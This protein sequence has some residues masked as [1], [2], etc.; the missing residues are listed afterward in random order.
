MNSHGPHKLIETFVSVS[1]DSA[2]KLP[3][4]RRR[5][6]FSYSSL[7]A[8]AILSTPDRRLTLREI[9]QW[10]MERYPA[11]YKAGD[12]GW[13]NTIRHN[14]SLN[15]CFKKIPRAENDVPHI[16][17][18]KGGYWTVDPEFMSSFEN[19][20]F[21]KGTMVRRK[22]V[23]SNNFDGFSA[24]PQMH[25]V[26]HYTSPNPVEHSPLNETYQCNHES[27]YRKGSLDQY[28]LHSKEPVED[29]RYRRRSEVSPYYY[30]NSTPQPYS[31]PY[32]QSEYLQP[33]LL[34]AGSEASS[35][36]SSSEDTS[37]L[38]IHNILN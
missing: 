15:K 13:Q 10:I 25:G 31:R 1:P 2:K 27:T 28:L 33:M 19:G 7:I 3:R 29:E 36:K 11:M 32:S 16:S 9:Y 21:P 30:A 24:A 26:F 4:K 23:E 8:Q 5:P 34:R 38:R 35:C 17:K 37:V 12:T 20:E 22:P 6:P 14:L 18:G